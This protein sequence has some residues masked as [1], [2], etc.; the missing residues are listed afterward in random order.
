[1]HKL[2]K[3]AHGRTLARFLVASFPSILLAAVPGASGG[4]AAI[5]L[6]RST[7]ETV[8]GTVIARVPVGPGVAYRMRQR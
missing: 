6:L 1:M 3:I 8:A 7:A 2:R 4:G 5:L